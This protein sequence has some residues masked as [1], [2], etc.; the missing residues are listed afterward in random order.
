MFGRLALG[1]CVQATP[2]SLVSPRKAVIIKLRVGLEKL[3][4][5]YLS[6]LDTDVY[7]DECQDRG[8][9]YLDTSNA[10]LSP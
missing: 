2:N 9:F 1:K 7:I 8:L 5:C 10:Q 6:D 3:T 4:Y